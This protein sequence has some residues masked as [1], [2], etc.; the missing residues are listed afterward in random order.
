M[1]A[2]LLASA[3]TLGLA[4]ATAAQAQDN[5]Q[6]LEKMQA[7]GTPMEAFNYVPQTGEYADQL[8]KNL[9]QI[10]LPPGFKINL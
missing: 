8:R 1:R 4:F 5:M 2:V 9:E 10:R 3:A 6:K 7:T